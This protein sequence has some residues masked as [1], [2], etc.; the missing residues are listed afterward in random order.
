[1][2]FPLGKG[3]WQCNMPNWGRSSVSKPVLHFLAWQ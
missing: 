1:M 3:H 2:T